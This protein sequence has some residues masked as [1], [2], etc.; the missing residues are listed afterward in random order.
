MHSLLPILGNAARFGEFG[1]GVFS[2]NVNFEIPLV[3]I[4]IPRDPFD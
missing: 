1:G 4:A 2:R 3:G